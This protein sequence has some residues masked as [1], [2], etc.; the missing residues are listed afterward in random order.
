MAARRKFE[1]DNEFLRQQ[2]KL[3]KT[4]SDNGE[5]SMSVINILLENPSI[6]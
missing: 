1:P 6:A 2:R 5:K 4:S 3:I